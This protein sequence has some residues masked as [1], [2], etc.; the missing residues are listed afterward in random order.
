VPVNPAPGQELQNAKQTDNF[1]NL[2]ENLRE[3]R[4]TFAL[5]SLQYCSQKHCTL[6]PKLTALHFPEITVFLFPVY[7]GFKK[8]TKSIGKKR[9]SLKSDIEALIGSL[10]QNPLQGEPLGKD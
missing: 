8:H 6:V 10:E 4:H 7:T 1:L 3:N 9:H 2:D 5:E